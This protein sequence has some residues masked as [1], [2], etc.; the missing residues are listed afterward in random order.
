MLKYLFFLALFKVLGLL[1]LPA[2]YRVAYGVGDLGY[3]LFPGVRANVWD[4]LRHVFPPGT[5][6][7]TIRR[8]ARQ[9]FRNVALY[10]ADMA[11]IP[12]IDVQE[13]FDKRLGV[14]GLFE[15]LIPAV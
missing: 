2:L 8:A 15:L 7:R 9:V 12:R 14:N 6:K 11:A 4:N 3:M 1:P 13:L 5:P 10:Y